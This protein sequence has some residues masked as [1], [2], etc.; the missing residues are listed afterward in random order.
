[1]ATLNPAYQREDYPALN[2][3]NFKTIEF[4]FGDYD[5]SSLQSV[6]RHMCDDEPYV[7]YEDEEAA[8]LEQFH[9][10]LIA[11][12]DDLNNWAQDAAVI[13]D[14]AYGILANL[15]AYGAEELSMNT[16]QFT[17]YTEGLDEVIELSDKYPHMYGLAGHVSD[18]RAL[19][20]QYARNKLRPILFPKNEE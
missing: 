6:A 13:G 18:V 8:N 2:E 12:D 11:R 19:Q 14:A 17:M 20:S 5:D 10:A 9:D 3:N 16:A 4:L 1:M 7:D 15:L